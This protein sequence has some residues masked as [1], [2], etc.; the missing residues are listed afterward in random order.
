MRSHM[1]VTF[2][3]LAT[4]GL[5][6]SV[7]IQVAGAVS[8]DALPNTSTVAS[9][10]KLST[11]LFNIVGGET[12]RRRGE[13][14]EVVELLARTFVARRRFSHGFGSLRLKFGLPKFGKKRPQPPPK[15]PAALGTTGPSEPALSTEKELRWRLENMRED[16]LVA[17]ARDL[18]VDG[19]ESF[20]KY[21]MTPPMRKILEDPQWKL[22][23]YVNK[24][25]RDIKSLAVT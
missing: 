16:E 3:L 4:V 9:S 23:E 20:I 14:T 7:P 13:P 10:G 18:P 8:L 24:M 22:P 1:A 11:P 2:A 25:L 19:L 12:S 15:R 21:H 6:M 5:A 17:Y